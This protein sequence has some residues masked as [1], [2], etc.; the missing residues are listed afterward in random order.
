MTEIKRVPSRFI[1]CEER[2]RRIEMVMKKR[3]VTAY[4]VS[5]ETG[6]NYSQFARTLNSEMTISTL[7]KIANYLGISAGFLMDKEIPRAR[8]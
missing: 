8:K 5:K 3:G 2:K 6:I 1:T 4:R 7:Y